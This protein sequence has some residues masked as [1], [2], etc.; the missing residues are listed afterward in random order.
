MTYLFSKDCQ[1]TRT[2]A[3]RYYSAPTPW[4]TMPWGTLWE[5]VSV[6][7][8]CR[9]AINPR[10]YLPKKATHVHWSTISHIIF[11]ICYTCTHFSTIDVFMMIF[12]FLEMEFYKK[13]LQLFKWQKS[14]TFY[15]FNSVIYNWLGETASIY[16]IPDWR[17][18]IVLMCCTKLI[19][20]Y[21]LCSAM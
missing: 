4:V 19:C 20:V 10:I 17:N 6:S 14:R 11:L 5:G 7:M 15:K 21:F 8:T 3:T 9:A 1:I 16:K 13:N 12:F 18:N 2:T